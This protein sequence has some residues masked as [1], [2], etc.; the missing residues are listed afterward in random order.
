MSIASVGSR[1][2]A[3][4][5]LLSSRLQAQGLSA[6]KTALVLGD[7]KVALEKV[8][9]VRGGPPDKAAIRDALESRIAA[10]VAS[11]K[12]TEADAKT[13]NDTLDQ[14][15]PQSPPPAH[16]QDAGGHKGGGPHGGGG[17]GGGGSANKTELSETVT[18]TG[19]LKKTTI[20]YTDGTSESTTTVLSD[21]AKDSKY[22]KS[23]VYDLMK[24]SAET[25]AAADKTRNYLATLDPGSLFSFTV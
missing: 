12:L 11:G 9:S 17:E 5:A 14:I 4:S 25:N 23:P 10:D 7:A 21:S 15:D 1:D 8:Q 3:Y 19:K 18:V 22:V 6:Q 20:L 13:V 2:A 24:A 16:P